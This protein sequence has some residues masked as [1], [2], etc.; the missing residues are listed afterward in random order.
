MKICDYIREIDLRMPNSFTDDEKISFLN[1]TLREMY[2]ICSKELEHKAAA[3]D[4]I[5]LPEGIDGDSIRAVFVGESEYFERG[6]VRR[7]KGEYEISERR[8]HLLPPAKSEA[9]IKYTPLVLF[10]TIGEITADGNIEEKN[11]AYEN[12]NGNIPDKYAEILI[13]GAVYK[14]ALA[15]E[16]TA[17]AA[18][19]KM[20]YEERRLRIMLDRYKKGTYP[21][22]KIVR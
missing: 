1:H 4:E 8:M 19:Y 3:D 2:K 13:L 20:W 12:Q 5:L 9:V 22:T 7:A 11:K 17:L 10:K 16:D 18:S 15:A 14:A 21:V 6:K